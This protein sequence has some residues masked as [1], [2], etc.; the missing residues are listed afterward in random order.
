MIRV[1]RKSK[2]LLIMILVAPAIF[3]RQRPTGAQVTPPPRLPVIDYD[4]CPFEGCTF[5]KW[6]V[7]RQTPIFTTW[8][9][10]RQL[11]ST[12]EKGAVVAALTGVHITYQPDR[13]QVTKAIPD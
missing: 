12:L 2:C 4:A 8:N 10:G 9:E 13:I 3:A 7:T 11:E 6:L 5:R 1:M